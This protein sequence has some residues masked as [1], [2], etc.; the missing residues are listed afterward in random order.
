[1][2]VVRLAHL[3]AL[4]F[5]SCFVGLVTAIFGRNFSVDRSRTFHVR[6]EGGLI[7]VMD[8]DLVP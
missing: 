7:Q 8:G 5:T 2:G 6:L 3:L 4:Q 1:M